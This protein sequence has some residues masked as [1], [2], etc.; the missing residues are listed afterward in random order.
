MLQLPGVRTEELRKPNSNEPL[1][2][3]HANRLLGGDS[4]DWLA[5][6]LRA[7]RAWIKISAQEWRR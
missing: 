7:G 4:W 3:I 1:E 2:G 5:T 6:L